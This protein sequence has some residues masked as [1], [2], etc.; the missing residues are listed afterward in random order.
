MSN[1]VEFCRSCCK[2]LSLK[3]S[4]FTLKVC[5]ACRKKIPPAR[6]IHL[7]IL[8]SFQKQFERFNDRLEIFRDKVDGEEWKE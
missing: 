1:M 3:E 5:A 4:S 2:E 6:L 8:A 7:D